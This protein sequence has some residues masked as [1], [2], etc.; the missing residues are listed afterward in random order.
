MRNGGL[1]TTEV[2]TVTGATLSGLRNPN[3][4]T[5]A[6]RTFRLGVKAGAP[7]RLVAMLGEVDA[8]FLVWTRTDDR[9]SVAATLRDCSG[10]LEHF[11]LSTP[12][13]GIAI[14]EVPPPTI[15]SYTEWGGLGGARSTCG[16]SL[17]DRQWSTDLLNGLYRELCA[18]HGW[19]FISLSNFVDLDPAD[20]R[21]TREWRSADAND[22]H[23]D[24]GRLGRELSLSL[25]DWLAE[26]S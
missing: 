1:E 20:H 6:M 26:G 11:L 14:V 4:S 10:N 21:P 16:A 12:A 5:D 2:L 3:S 25:R 7:G 17:A 22:H 8:G 15:V 23:L 9:N 19:A 13:A 18:T 24:S